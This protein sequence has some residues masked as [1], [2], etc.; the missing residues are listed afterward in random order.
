[1]PSRS[2]SPA[3]QL[4]PVDVNVLSRRFRLPIADLSLASAQ[5]VALQPEKWARHFHVVPLS[6][7][8]QELV[9]ATADPLDVDCERTLGFATGRHIRLTLADSGEIGQRIEELYRAEGPTREPEAAVDVQHL[10]NRDD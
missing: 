9:I 8:A 4:D 7:T 10:D 2:I 1:M 5:A 6:A 3:P